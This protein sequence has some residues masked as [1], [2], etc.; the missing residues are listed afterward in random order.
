MSMEEKRD[1]LYSK[2][3]IWKII[4]IFI[5]I[6]FISIILITGIIQHR[7]NI[8][9]YEI[10]HAHFEELVRGHKQHI[11]FFLNEKVSNIRHLSRNVDPELF[12]DN[13][14]LQERLHNLQEDYNLDFVDLE[15]VDENGHQVA[16]AGPSEFKNIFHGNTGWFKQTM[17]TGYYISDVIKGPKNQPQLMVATKVQNENSQGILKATIDVAYFNSLLQNLKVGET[18]T[19]FIL[20]RNG[21]VQVP[22]PGKITITPQQYLSLF[23]KDNQTENFNGDDNEP[24]VSHSD[25][26]ISVEKLTGSNQKII[27]GSAFLK[28]NEWILIFQEDM[29][30]ALAGL[31]FSRIFV[32]LIFLLSCLG[33]ILS[34]ILLF[35][36]SR[37][38]K[39]KVD[40]GKELVMT[41]QFIETDKLDSIG[42]LASGIAHEI[43][44]PVA[45]MV[46][47]AGWVQD[48]IHE[49]IDKNDNLEEFIRAMKQI[50]T[51]GHRCKEI[52]RKLLS[53][54]RKFDSRIENI[55]LNDL[56]EEVVTLSSEKA[57]HANVKIHTKLDPH[58]PEIPASVT[59]MQ[60][61][62]T[63]IINNGLDAM[64]N[65][66]DRLDIISML[67]KDQIIITIRDN[68]PGIQSINLNRVFDPFFSTKPVGKGSGLGLSICYSIIKKMGGRIDFESVLGEGSAF[69]IVLPKGLFKE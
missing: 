58:L 17:E 60:Q 32:N 21:E 67:Q 36:R 35:L 9:S 46:E 54:G 14:F 19:A 66:G 20:N 59:E 6:T 28:N 50:E 13:P 48:L 18:G 42:E 40:S 63:N 8:F 52:T 5:G 53:F 55:Q 57:R 45:I 10:V 22:P 39:S 41:E 33:L 1:T 65:K 2:E 4:I 11:D 68:G 34:C 43:N 12:E 15:L 16:Y 29:D 23:D 44:N 64:E 27:I 47:E 62:L 31:N 69:H 49:G 61:V 3:N 37:K 51:Q 25:S 26:I 30:E 7:F 38:H 56:I 24:L